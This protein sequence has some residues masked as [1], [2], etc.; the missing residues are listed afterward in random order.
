MERRIANPVWF[1]ETTGST[2]SNTECA[3]FSSDDEHDAS[4]DS[5]TEDPHIV[6]MDRNHT[7]AQSERQK[8]RDRFLELEQGENFFQRQQLTLNRNMPFLI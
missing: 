3:R 6:N 2:I 1:G 8:N 4:D 7:R 5:G